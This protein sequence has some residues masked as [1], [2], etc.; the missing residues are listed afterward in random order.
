MGKGQ[1]Q[2]DLK[3]EGKA[4][5]AFL[6]KLCKALLGEEPVLESVPTWWCGDPASLRYVLD[7]FDQLVIKPAFLATRMEPE[8]PAERLLVVE[9]LTPGEGR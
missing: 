7:H 9:V 1:Q 2:A 6:P 4:L 3:Q 8:F 5:L